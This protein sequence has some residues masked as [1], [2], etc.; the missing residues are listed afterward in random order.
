MGIVFFRHTD[1]A[2]ELD[3]GI[4]IGDRGLASEML[5]GEQVRAGIAAVFL[6]RGGGKP[7][8]RPR[9]I[10]AHCHI[11]DGVSYRLP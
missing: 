10:G 11:G 5:G 8:L 6:H 3:I 7:Q 4:G 1:P 9:S 2:V